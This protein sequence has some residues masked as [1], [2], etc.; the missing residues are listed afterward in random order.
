VKDS[1]EAEG[2]VLALCFREPECHRRATLELSAEHFS[3]DVTRTVWS[4]I[5]KLEAPLDLALVAQTLSA[6]KDLERVGGKPRL[7]AFRFSPAERENFSQYVRVLQEARAHRRLEATLTKAAQYVTNAKDDLPV[8]TTHVEDMLASV[9]NDARVTNE[10]SSMSDVLAAAY[11]ETQRAQDNPNGVAGYRTFFPPVDELIGGLEPGH[12]TTLMGEPGTGK[13]ALAL[14]MALGASRQVPVGFISLEMTT[15]DLG[16]RIQACSGRLDYGLLRAGRLSEPAAETRD[17]ITSALMDSHNLWVAPGEVEGWSESAAWMSHM[18]Y[19]R[20][21]R[22]FV[23]DNVLSLDYEGL[24]EYE[25]VTRVATASQR[26][27]KKLNV[28][29]LNLHHTNT[30][31]KPTLRSAHGAKGIVRHSS[32]V[33]ALWR[34]EVE[35]QT[36]LL[37]ELKGRNMGRGERLLRFI[38]NQ[39]RFAELM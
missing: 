16:Q 27:A 19:A 6:R 10:G 11:I 7:A 18:Y 39:Q 33:L 5:S 29:L 26:L 32:N 13:T 9:L 3:D 36:V 2:A 21:V 30:D 15:A 20:G 37:S 23:L 1:Q 22:V 28:A 34:E 24:D 4:A 25:H 17:R 14:Q 35:S 38:G 8:L 12:V 31:E